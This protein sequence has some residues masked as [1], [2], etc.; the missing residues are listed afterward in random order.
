MKRLVLGAIALLLLSGASSDRQRAVHVLNRLAFGARPGD[1]DKVL[2]EG[3]DVWIDRQLHPE[4]IP[5]REVD[6]RLQAI[7]TFWMRSADIMEKYYAPVVQARRDR[8]AG[9]EIDASEV[10]MAQQRSRELL[11]DLIAQRIIRAA[12]SQR[13]LNEVMVDFWFNHFNVFAGKG[14]DRYMLTSYERDTIRPR[15]WGR[16]EDLLMA[17]AKSPAMLFYLDNAR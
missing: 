17:T 13:Q 6:T 1:V 16:F 4:R 10:K 12:E 14:I 9:E 5:D 11:E 15:V 7:S 8:K 2:D 3:V